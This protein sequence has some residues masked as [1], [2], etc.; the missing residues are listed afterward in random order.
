[1]MICITELRLEK[2]ASEDRL[3]AELMEAEIAELLS[4]STTPKCSPT[5]SK[6]LTPKPDDKQNQCD[7]NSTTASDT[8]LNTTTIEDDRF[9]MFH[10]TILAMAV[11][12][13]AIALTTLFPYIG[14]MIIDVGVASN[15]NEA[16][17]YSGAIGE[18]LYVY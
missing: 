2:Q 16:G 12:S 11:L 1:M 3:K 13:S 9:P 17:Y 14:F 7:R 8:L 15:I 10:M 18:C 5:I 6:S 4:P